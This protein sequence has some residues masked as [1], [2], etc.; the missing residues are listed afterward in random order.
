[1]SH[2]SSIGSKINSANGKRRGLSRALS[3]NVDYI[4]DCPESF[5]TTSLLSTLNAP[6]S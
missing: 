5:S 3:Y 2:Q 4:P 6:K 1:M